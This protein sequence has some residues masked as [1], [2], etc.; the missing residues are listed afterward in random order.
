MLFAKNQIFYF[1]KIELL[2]I[3]FLFPCTLR[4]IIS[5][6]FWVITFY[7]SSR[8]SFLTDDTLIFISSLFYILNSFDVN[9]T[10]FFFKITFRNPNCTNIMNPDKV[11]SW[12]IIWISIFVEIVIVYFILFFFVI[13]LFLFLIKRFICAQ[14]FLFLFVK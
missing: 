4:M 12:C 14:I 3:N 7:T 6:T 8:F 9:S 1:L 5:F 2:H 11:A 10:I 13:L